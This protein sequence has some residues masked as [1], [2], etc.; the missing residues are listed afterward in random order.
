MSEG[1]TRR[2]STVASVVAGML[3]VVLLGT[4]AATP[5][6]AA[7]KHYDG[8]VLG[9]NENANTFRIRT[10]SGKVKFKVNRRTEFE[11]IRGGFAGLDRGDRVE[12]DAKRKRHRLVARQVEPQGGG[13]ADDN[14]GDDNGGDDNGGHGSD[15]PPGDDHGDH[16]PGHD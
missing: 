6:S 14:G 15:D 1:R 4:L 10:E 9:T 16:G 5:A 2:W 12:V 7:L 13:G 8:T 11:R 3:M